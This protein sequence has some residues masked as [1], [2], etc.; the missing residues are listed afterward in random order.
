VPVYVT[1]VY[2]FRQAGEI[3]IPVG[4]LDPRHARHV[5]LQ[6]SYCR[7]TQAAGVFDPRQERFLQLLPKCNQISELLTSTTIN[8][9]N[10]DLRHVRHVQLVDL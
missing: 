3:H 4:E 7:E 8:L 10:V 5:A 6:E 2:K 9:K 1:L